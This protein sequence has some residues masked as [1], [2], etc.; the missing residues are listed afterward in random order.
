MVARNRHHKI[1]KYDRCIYKLQRSA[2]L[3]GDRPRVHYSDAR[4][5]TDPYLDPSLL[6]P[7]DEAQQSEVLESVERMLESAEKMVFRKNL[8]AVYAKYPMITTT[9]SKLLFRVAPRSLLPLRIEPTAESAPSNCRLH[10]YSAKQQK[11]M[12]SSTSKLTAAGKIFPNPSTKG[13]PP[14]HCAYAKGC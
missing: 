2:Q 13:L 8:K 6:D 14:P 12:R 11:V 4:N 3:L 5:D 10:N 7:A 9:Y 1:T